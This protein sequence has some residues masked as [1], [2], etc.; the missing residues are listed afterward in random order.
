MSPRRSAPSVSGEAL[1]PGANSGEGAGLVAVQHVLPLGSARGGAFAERAAREL[2]AAMRGVE[3]LRAW[4]DRD[5][6]GGVDIGVHQEVVV[7]DLL[8]VRAVAEARCLEEVAQ[9]APQV[10]HLRDLVS[11]AL[12]SEEHT[13]ELQSRFDLV[14]RL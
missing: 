10:R 6:A 7:L 13:S 1:Q 9:V 14:C 8:E 2:F 12:R 3:D 5:H 11:I 4:A